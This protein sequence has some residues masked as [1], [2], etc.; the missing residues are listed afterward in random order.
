M[1]RVCCPKCDAK[2]KVAADYHR[3][4]IRCDS[5][6]AK[7]R[8][9]QDDDDMPTRKQPAKSGGAGGCFLLGGYAVALLA[10][11][12]CVVI[13]FFQPGVAMLVAAIMGLVIAV[14]AGIG[15]LVT[16]IVAK[17]NNRSGWVALPWLGVLLLGSLLILG[18]IGLHGVAKKAG[19][20]GPA[21]EEKAGDGIAKGDGARIDKDADRKPPRDPEP[22]KLEKPLPAALKLSGDADLDKTLNDLADQQGKAFKP[23][24]DRL[25]TM[26]PNEHRAI[27]AQHLAER[28]RTA[29]LYNR[30][31]L[32]RALAVWGTPQEVPVLIQLLNDPD[33][34]TRNESLKALGQIKDERAAAPMARCLLEVSTQYHAEQALKAMGP[35]AETEVLGVLKQNQAQAK[36]VALGILTDIGTP[37]SLPALEEAAR[38]ASLRGAAQKAIAAI[39]ARK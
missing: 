9:D 31:P 2:V 26:P 17:A 37:K 33:I 18:P 32:L 38:T 16:W 23:A 19:W 15:H 6:G 22:P 13:A 35:I 1:A 11:V 7:I 3:P 5:C 10:I 34:N 36:I 39:N 25:I 8:L 21:P 24:V 30:T 28:A 29:P 12:L 14:L 20:L 27:V 4:F